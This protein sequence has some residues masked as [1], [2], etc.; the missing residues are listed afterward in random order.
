MCIRDSF[1]AAGTYSF[2]AA[3]APSDRQAANNYTLTGA[4]I[5]YVITRR[6]VTIQ[7]NNAS[8]YYAEEPDVV[9]LGYTYAE[10]SAEFVADDS[11]TFEY[12]TTATDSSAAGSYTKMCI[13]DRQTDRDRR[14]RRIF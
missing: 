8:M 2:T 7:A 14:I 13:R 6:S 11:L 9:S 12:G 3:F 5:D 4:K 10:N 1:E